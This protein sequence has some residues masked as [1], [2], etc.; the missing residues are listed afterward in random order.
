MNRALCYDTVNKRLY[1]GWAD[2]NES[3]FPEHDK[4]GFK[5]FKFSI[6]NEPVEIVISSNLHYLGA[7]FL[8]AEFFIKGKSLL[9][10]KDTKSLYLVNHNEINTFQVRAGNWEE[11]FDTLVDTCNNHYLVCESDIDKYFCEIDNIIQCDKITVFRNKTDDHPNLWEGSFFVLLHSLDLITNIIKCFEDSILNNNKY[12]VNRI[13]QTCRLFMQR[14]AMCYPLWGK[15]EDDSRMERFSKEL[16]VVHSFINQ[17]GK[18]FE[19]VNFLVM[20]N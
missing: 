19:F 16:V 6:P 17:H 10:F 20:P 4:K 13:M 15:S 2:T 12:L 11:L 7:S 8:Y 18:S 5:T 3:L 14:F 9:N 1:V